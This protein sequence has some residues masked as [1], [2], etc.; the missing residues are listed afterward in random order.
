MVMSYPESS[1]IILVSFPLHSRNGKSNY[2]VCVIKYQ[3]FYGFRVPILYFSYF[4]LKKKIN[5]ER[6]VNDSVQLG[7]TH[8]RLLL[9]FLYFTNE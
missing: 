5:R 1:E 8:T 9:S 4:H 3:I 7:Q 2:T 6:V